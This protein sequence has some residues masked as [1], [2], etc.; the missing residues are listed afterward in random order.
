MASSD[1]EGVHRSGSSPRKCG[2]AADRGLEETQVAMRP[3]VAGI[4][5]SSAQID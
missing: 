5:E 3:M 4:R 2:E 1:E